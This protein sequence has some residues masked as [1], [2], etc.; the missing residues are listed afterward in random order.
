MGEVAK[1]WE[2][3]KTWEEDKELD[4]ESIDSLRNMLVHILSRVTDYDYGSF[5]CKCGHEF[6]TANSANLFKYDRDGIY[7]IN[8][9][10]DKC[11]ESKTVAMFDRGFGGIINAWR[12]DQTIWVGDASDE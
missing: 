3:I 7:A 9:I 5:R 12:C 10:C 11:E 6:K 8:V 2:N 1:F 4:K